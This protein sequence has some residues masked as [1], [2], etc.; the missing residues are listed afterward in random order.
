MIHSVLHLRPEVGLQD[1]KIGQ[2]DIAVGTVQGRHVETM[3][4]SEVTDLN[5]ASSRTP[6]RVQ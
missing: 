1:H 4:S 5:T 3:N 2:V 6:R